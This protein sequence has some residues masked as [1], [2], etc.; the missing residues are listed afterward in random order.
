MAE[1]VMYLCMVFMVLIGHAFGVP[2]AVGIPGACAAVLAV[3]KD[4][5]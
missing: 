5:L 2:D 1:I 4:I 3:F